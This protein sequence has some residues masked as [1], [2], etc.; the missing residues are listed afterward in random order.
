MKF[1]A[2]GRL[3][4][5]GTHRLHIICAGSGSPAVIFDAALGGS[6]L[7][8]A[9]VQPAVGRLTRACAYDRA[10]FSWSEAGPLP[11]TAGRIAGELH[12]LLRAADVAPPFVLVGHSFGGLVVRLFAQRHP[13]LTAGLVLLDPAHPEHWADPAD[14][15]RVQ[16]E[17]GAGLCRQGAR[18]ARFG[19]ARVVASLAG[20]GALRPA[21][22]LA[23]LV[24]RGGLRREDE[25]VLAP[26]WKLPPD[27]RRPLRHFWTEEKF[28]TAL[29]SQ[30]ESICESAREVAVTDRGFGDRPT[31]VI[32]AGNA[33]DDRLRLQEALARK[34]SRGRHVVAEGSGHW[35]PL[36]R[37][38]LVI[39]CIE[40]VVRA[41]RASGPAAG[42]RR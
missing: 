32:S 40:E 6:S 25:S 41:C 5:I 7:S 42:E 13:E 14:K 33:D 38:D 1:P 12:A 17:R 28:Y 39:E 9:L 30:I 34:S 27:A 10:G 8:W 4:D 36:D 31:I 11:R 23:A 29:G 24:S 35:I 18:A 19:V 15:E 26:A 22:A 16:I 3:I 37:P 21:R 20:L 2:P